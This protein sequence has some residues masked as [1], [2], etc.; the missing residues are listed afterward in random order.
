MTFP[1][2]A[3]AYNTS[4]W[5]NSSCPS[6]GMCG[7]ASDAASGVQK[8]EISIRQVSPSRYWNG[9]SFASSSEVFHTVTGTTDWSFAL[10]A[11]SYTVNG[12]YTIRVRATDTA[13]N[14]QS[15]SSRT[16]RYDAALPTATLTFPAA[17]G[18]Y[19]TTTWTNGC[20][21]AICGSASDTGGSGLARVEVSIVQQ[22]T[23]SYWDGTAFA[24]AAEVYVPATGTSSWRYAFPATSFPAAGSYVV[25]ARSSDLAG[26]TGNSSS[27]RTF[28]FTP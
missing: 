20:T 27:P 1:V 10:P 14:V 23:G 12:Q 6:P 18:N 11:S 25:R 8:V 28:N 15:P 26:N 22:A 4:G 16:Y 5:A 3:A 24:S 21:S 2:A 19:T 9:T 7:T 13:G 17:N